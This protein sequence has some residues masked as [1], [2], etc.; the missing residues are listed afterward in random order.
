MLAQVHAA[1][2]VHDRP[3]GLVGDDL[4]LVEARGQGLAVLAVAVDGELVQ[5]FAREVVGFGHVLR[6][7]HHRQ[8]RVGVE[9]EVRDL[10][11]EVLRVVRRHVALDVVHVVTGLIEGGEAVAL[12]AA[13][14]ELAP[15]ALRAHGDADL[16][17]AD[18]DALGDAVQGLHAAAALPRHVEGADGFR[19]A[20]QP[21]H[22]VA[23][24]AAELRDAAHVA[25]ADLLDL[26]GV[27]LRVALQERLQHLDA[28]LV[29]AGRGEAAASTLRERRAH[30]V[31]QYYVLQIHCR[32]PL[33][34]TRRCGGRVGGSRL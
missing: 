12:A 11:R 26:G 19:Q 17:R 7:L 24:E 5:L 22:V 32:S 6:G 13:A 28:D 30:A 10:L 27:E 23:P 15:H 3:L 8:D 21:G 31:D 25:E 9:D 20:G 29:Q 33:F 14:A 18:H 4:V 1:V 34:R 16:R 2:V